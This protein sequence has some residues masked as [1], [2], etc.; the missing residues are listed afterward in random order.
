[1][2]NSEISGLVQKCEANNQVFN[3]HWSSEADCNFSVRYVNLALD[4]QIQKKRRDPGKKMAV[5][6]ICSSIQPTIS[7]LSMQLT[8]ISGLV[9]CEASK[10]ILK[11]LWSSETDCNLTVSE[12]KHYAA[13][14]YLNK[15]VMVWNYC[16]NWSVCKAVFWVVEGRGG[17]DTT[18]I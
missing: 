5:T 11:V 6:R 4:H 9:K 1:M 15:F 12:S 13:V 7:T 18:R 17:I 3:V 8:I 10:Q 16:C 14:F 2:H